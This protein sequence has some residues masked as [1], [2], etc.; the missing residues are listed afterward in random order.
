MASITKIKTGWRAQVA[1]KGVRKSRVFPTK[2]AA[3][4][5]ALEVEAAILAEASAPYP[6]KTLAQ[7]LDRYLAEVSVHKRS[8][9]AERLRFEALKRDFH[10]LCSK[11]LHTITP[12]D[13]A[14]WRDARRRVVSDSSVVREGGTLK[15]LW[16][17]ARD[18]WG[19]C[20]ESPWERVKL[21]P[22][23]H[24]RTRQT[25]PAELRRILRGLGYVTGRRPSTPQQQVAWAYL[26][27]HHTAMRASEILSLSRS[28]VDLRQRVARLDRHKTDKSVGVRHV[29]FTRKAA[30]L[31]A[32]LDAWAEA[33][34]RDRYFT[35]SAQ[36]LDVL[37]RRV[38]DRLLI[39][40]L[41]FHD[42]RAAALTRLSRR[43]DVLRLAKISGHKDLRQLLDAYYRASAAEIAASI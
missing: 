22:K 1:R 16:R 9:R 24:A 21:P 12:A 40:D 29:P 20:G 5:W 19:W 8:A 36:S 4:A 28:T 18:E 38:R 34:G 7:A 6:N 37:F 41:R 25:S 33:D 26:V 31:L 11:V 27:A 42:A 35:I 2:A 39:G 30:R 32:A 14:A 17:I 15:N 10:E 13:I 43:M 23:A 3:Q